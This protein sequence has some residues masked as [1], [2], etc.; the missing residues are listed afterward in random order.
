MPDKLQVTI[1]GLGLVG[2][3]AGLALRRYPDKVTVVGH[4][5]DAGKSAQAKSMGA[6]ERTE[7]N[8]I[9]A[10]SKADRVLLALPVNEIRETMAA[11]APDLKPGCVLV[12]TATVK[13]VVMR[14]AR[15]SFAQHRPHGGWTPY[16]V[17]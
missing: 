3:A 1:V 14:W 12:D 13:Q 9:N 10:I 17:F 15:E 5:R 6:V 11:I 2:T 16:P 4:D 8:L 7:W